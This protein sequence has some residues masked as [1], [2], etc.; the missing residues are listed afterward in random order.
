MAIKE[1][2]PDDSEIVKYFQREVSMLRSINS[3]RCSLFDVDFDRLSLWFFLCSAARHPNIV[4]FLGIS[5]TP[6]G[7]FLIVT[8][9]IISFIELLSNGLDKVS[10]IMPNYFFDLNSC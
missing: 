10:E 1:L 9:E 3:L 4:E 6:E 7:N 2:Y 8:G 5:K